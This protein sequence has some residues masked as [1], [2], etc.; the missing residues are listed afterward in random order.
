MKHKTFIA[1]ALLSVAG[2]AGVFTAP[3]V[4]AAVTCP[5]GSYRQIHNLPADNIAQ[6]NMPETET[7]ADGEEKTLIW[8]IG[9][10]I[11]VVLG[12]V[13]IIAVVVIIIGGISFITSQGDPGKVTKARNTI[14][15]GVIGV[16]VALL[17]FTIV[18]FVLKSIGSASTD[19]EASLPQSSLIASESALP[20]P[21]FIANR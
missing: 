14:L 3:P 7:A 20:Q 19:D 2:L 8:Y 12:L 16:V 21:D 5:T 15:Y 9:T 6:C 10:V 1:A 4:S 11:N 18:T 17:A 13:G